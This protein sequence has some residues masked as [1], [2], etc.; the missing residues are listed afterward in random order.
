MEQAIDGPSEDALKVYNIRDEL[1]SDMNIV[2]TILLQFNFDCEKRASDF[3]SCESF[4]GDNKWIRFPEY[5]MP[6][7]TLCEYESI[8]FWSVK[9]F[10]FFFF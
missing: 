1:Q 7:L 3:K 10:I 2:K 4:I 9:D 6:D 8:L 5:P